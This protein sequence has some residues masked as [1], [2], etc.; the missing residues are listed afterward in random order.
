MAEDINLQ[1]SLMEKRLRGMF[2]CSVMAPRYNDFVLEQKPKQ[3]NTIK[4]QTTKMTHL[5]SKRFLVFAVA[6][7]EDISTESLPDIDRTSWIHLFPGKVIS[8][9]SCF[10]NYR[11]F[12]SD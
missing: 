12:I 7:F 1:L 5:Y 10:V 11:L 3:T 6:L 4:K 9:K 2:R 8:L